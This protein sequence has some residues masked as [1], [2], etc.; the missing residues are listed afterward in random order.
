MARANAPNGSA[1]AGTLAGACPG[2]DGAGPSQDGP[3]RTVAAAPCPAAGGGLHDRARGRR[4]RAMSRSPRPRRQRCRRRPRDGGDPRGRPAQCGARPPAQPETGRCARRPLAGTRPGGGP[5]DP[6]LRPRRQGGGRGAAPG[7]ARQS[8][9]GPARARPAAH[10]LRR[11]GRRAAHR[12][13][14]WAGRARRGAG[15]GRALRPDRRDPPRDRPAHRLA[16]GLVP[17]RLPAVLDGLRAHRDR[18]GL[19]L[20]DQPRRRGRGHPCARA[21]AHRHGAEPRALRPVGLGPRAR[22]HLL[23]GVDVR[24]AGHGGALRLHV[25]RRGERPHAPA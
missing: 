7:R 25:V 9:V 16:L 3:V 2:T 13:R 24:H 10:G 17:V 8:A 14:Q 15:A 20:A 6:D 21:W 18:D 1:Y 12:S 22:P 23:V 5:A 11:Q 19:L 4:R